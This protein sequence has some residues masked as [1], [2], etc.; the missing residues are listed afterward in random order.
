[1]L[2][3]RGRLNLV[4]IFMNRSELAA[5][6]VVQPPALSQVRHF[7]KW[8]FSRALVTPIL[9]ISDLN[10]PDQFCACSCL[11]KISSQITTSCDGD[12]DEH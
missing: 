10:L 2:A 3:D 8:I 11:D 1:M 7:R 6:F 9:S 4:R 12:L 5:H